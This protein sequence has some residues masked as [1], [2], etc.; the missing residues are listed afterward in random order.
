MYLVMLHV[1]WIFISSSFACIAFCVCSL[2]E[3]VWRT[4][5]LREERTGLLW[6]GLQS[7]EAMLPPADPLSQICRYVLN[8]FTFLVQLFGD[9][10]FSCSKPCRGDGEL[11]E[12]FIE[13]ERGIGGEGERGERGGGGRGGEGEGGERERERERGREKREP[14]LDIHHFSRECSEQ[15]VV[16]SALQVH[17]L[18][19]TAGHIKVW[20]ILY[21]HVNCDSPR[22]HTRTYSSLHWPLKIKSSITLPLI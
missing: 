2:W 12:W 21:V 20:G 22:M 3:T 6:E 1:S 17:C 11:V 10:C 19:C 5:S 15:D 13:R 14:Y 9:V 16:Y 18:W 8:F 7:G 4:S